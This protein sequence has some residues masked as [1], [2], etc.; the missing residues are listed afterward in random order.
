MAE[1]SQLIRSKLR[2]ANPFYRL[3]ICSFKGTVLRI[4]V[5]SGTSSPVE[6]RSLLFRVNV[7]VIYCTVHTVSWAQIIVG[8]QI[9]ISGSLESYWK[10]SPTKILDKNLWILILKLCMRYCTVC[11]FERGGKMDSQTL[12]YSIPIRVPKYVN[13]QV[14]SSTNGLGVREILPLVWYASLF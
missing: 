6:K 10:P 8:I 3:K 12:V 7:T 4:D 5:K 13:I 9:T 14:V 2:S 1:K 11:N